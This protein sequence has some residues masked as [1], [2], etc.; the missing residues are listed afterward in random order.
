MRY[1]SRHSKRSGSIHVVV[2]YMLF[3]LS[4][5][6]VRMAKMFI[7]GIIIPANGS[8]YCICAPCGGYTSPYYLITICKTHVYLIQMS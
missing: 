7:I 2:T 3:C 4:S 1:S 6:V 8:L 5:N